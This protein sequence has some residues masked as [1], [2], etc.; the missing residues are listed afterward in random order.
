MLHCGIDC[1]NE[2]V[3]LSAV[4]DYRYLAKTTTRSHFM[5]ITYIV[6]LTEMQKR[7]IPEKGFALIE[8][9]YHKYFR[10]LIFTFSLQIAKTFELMI[11]HPNLLHYRSSF[12]KR[13][14]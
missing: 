14:G 9:R 6:F 10:S 4:V 8:K 13:F 1:W 5:L 3:E 12:Q 2:L 7:Q 11:S